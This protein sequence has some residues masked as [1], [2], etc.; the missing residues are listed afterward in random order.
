MFIPKTIEMLGIDVDRYE[1]ARDM[2][3]NGVS[4][5]AV[6]K[7]TSCFESPDGIQKMEISDAK[8]RANSPMAEY[9]YIEKERPA[10]VQRYHN[11]E[12]SLEDAQ[13]QLEKLNERRKSAIYR[14]ENEKQGTL[15][16]ILD[17]DELFERLPELRSLPVKTFDNS[18][19]NVGG[20]VSNYNS[21][22]S[23]DRK[24]TLG[25][26]QYQNPE[27]LLKYLL[28]ELQHIIQIDNGWSSG[29]SPEMF[30]ERSDKPEY[31]QL[32]DETV[33]KYKA[34]DFKGMSQRILEEAKTLTNMP[35]NDVR[36]Y[37]Y[38]KVLTGEEQRTIRDYTMIVKDGENR[39]DKYRSLLG[40]IESYSVMERIGLT[41]E[42]RLEQM[43][44][45][46]QKTHLKTMILGDS[47]Y[48][49]NQLLDQLTQEATRYLDN[50][51][52]MAV[53]Y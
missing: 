53:N 41:E 11:N 10:L 28:H 48:L 27:K 33:S 3:K 29:G 13:A 25:K 1:Q 22:Y 21:Q 9:N 12:I 34:L 5:K 8:A 19:S 43:P 40:E 42:E 31:E 2:L 36:L 51:E 16:Y 24:I 23:F 38:Q 26:E 30:F 17:H 45:S 15:G 49:T 6:F 44:Y 14:I 32:I 37:L 50:S 39:F 52:V 7:K 20:F 47:L 46:D 35:K 18:Q 4:P